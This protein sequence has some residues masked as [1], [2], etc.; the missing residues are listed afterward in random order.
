MSEK[1]EASGSA[2]GSHLDE[3][4]Q[5]RTSLESALE[6]NAHLMEDRDRLARRVAQ[7]SRDLQ[8]FRSSQPSTPYP[9]PPPTPTKRIEEQGQAEK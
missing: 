1:A 8:S 5:L 7:L 9:T 3:I 6:E 4:E 2:G